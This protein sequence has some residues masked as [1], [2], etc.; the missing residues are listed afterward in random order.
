MDL[1]T[2]QNWDLFPYRNRPTVDPEKKKTSE[3][4]PST[5]SPLRSCF[6]LWRKDN[7]RPSCLSPKLSRVHRGFLSNSRG[8]QKSGYPIAGWFTM[9]NPTYKWMSWGYPHIRSHPYVSIMMLPIARAILQGISCQKLKI[10]RT[11]GI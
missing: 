4:D 11:N 6:S 9:E 1:I 7:R 5:F 10:K 3:V 8:F 2:G